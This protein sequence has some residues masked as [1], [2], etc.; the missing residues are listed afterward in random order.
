MPFI[1]T[2]AIALLLIE[3]FLRRRPWAVALAAGTA[4]IATAVWIFSDYQSRSQRGAAAAVTASVV[5]D[6]ATCV[7]PALP[8]AATLSNN[9]GSAVNRLAFELFGREPGRSKIL[10]R[11]TLRHDRPLAS[12]ESITRC[13]PLLRHGF[14]HPRPQIIDATKYEWTTHVS[15]VGFGNAPPE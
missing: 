13:Y 14:S 4:V 3:L 8:V 7:D 11:G 2:A 1:I 6:A 5:A 9:S 12:G 10:Y 15:F